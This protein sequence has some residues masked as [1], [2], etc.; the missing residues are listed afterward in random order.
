MEDPNL[1]CLVDESHRGQYGPLHAKMR[2]VLPKA[3]FIGFTGTPV[4]KKEKNTID[5]FGGLIHSY[6]IGQ[7]VADHAV[8]PLLYEGRDVP[9]TVDAS[10]STAGLRNGQTA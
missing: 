1:F 8:V 4:L 10:N 5:R 7:A 3:C 2:Q 6:T 9:Q